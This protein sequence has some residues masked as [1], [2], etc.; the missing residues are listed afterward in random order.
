[1]LPVSATSFGISETPLDVSATTL[2]TSVAL[3]STTVTITEV[4]TAASSRYMVPLIPIRTY[5]YY[6]YLQVAPLSD[7]ARSLLWD[8]LCILSYSYI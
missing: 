6:S 3:L 8:C 2:A 4:H 7:D 5:D 1:M